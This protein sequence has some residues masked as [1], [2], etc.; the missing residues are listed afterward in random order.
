MPTKTSRER[1]RRVHRAVVLYFIFVFAAMIWPIYP[2]FSRV[3]PLILGMP[4]SLF[5]LVVLLLVSF[6]VM[7]SLY[8]WEDRRGEIE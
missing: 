6:G 3:R 2:L 4:F 8:F 5:Y 7:L 1:V